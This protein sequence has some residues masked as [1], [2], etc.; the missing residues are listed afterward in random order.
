MRRAFLV[1]TA[2]LCLAWP[3][4]TSAAPSA[5]LPS[6]AHVVTL[7]L[8][9][10]SFDAI[11]G[12]G[13]P[14][15][16]LKGLRSSGVFADHYYG[17]GHA[18]LDNY[19]A[20]VSGQ[21]DQPT[22]GSDCLSLNLY[23]CAQAQLALANGRNLADQL[24]AGRVS[25]KGYMDSMPSPCFHADY[26]PTATPDTYQGNSQAPPARD[27]ADRHNP[28]LYF[29]DIVGDDARCRAHVVPYTQ[30]S[31]DLAGDALPAFSFI[32]PDT[33]HDGHD[34]PCS[35]GKPGGLVS[36]DLWLSQEVPAL[37]SYLESHRGLL[38]VY[39]DEGAA[40][41][42]GGCCTGGP[43]GTAGF[44]GRVGLLALGAGLPHGKVVNTPYD[45][46]SLLR[47][48][49]DLFGIGEHLNNAATASPMTDVLAV[50][51]S[52]PP[53]RGAAAP[54]RVLPNTG[55]SPGF[56][57]PAAVGLFLPSGVVLA[58]LAGSRRTRGRD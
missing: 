6:F 7:V 56:G 28:F 51:T 10:E 16:Y 24:E 44:G 43:G 2:G 25:W 39:F 8:E 31:T 38:L 49:E 32:T 30:L 14:A 54:A 20:M 18:S 26:S 27:Y 9:N 15:N 1:L 45:H 50:S 46:A 5:G 13:S 40:S 48:L 58:I 4:A 55:R 41:D 22:T 11:W 33:C 57:L 29:P 52:A 42:T 35:N 37:L 53:S 17:I 12:P 47:T 19:V 21:P 3:A 36:A 34:N 23:T